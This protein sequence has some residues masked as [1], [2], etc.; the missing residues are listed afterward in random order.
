MATNSFDRYEQFRKNG[1]IEMVPF[2]EVPESS[3]DFFEIYKKGQTRLDQ[4]SYKY[5]KDANYAWLIMQANP[6]Y[7]S[8]EYRI[9]DGV[10]LRIPYP[11]SSAL[12]GYQQSIENYKKLYY[13]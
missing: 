11:L 6:A 3:S 2:G 10:T 7:G 1:K 5:Y 4:V 9:P 13:N 8:I 12:Q